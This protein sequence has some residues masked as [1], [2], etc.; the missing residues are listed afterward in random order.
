[1]KHTG[2]EGG[3]LKHNP[4]NKTSRI[5]LGCCQISH[6]FMAQTNL[7]PAVTWQQLNLLISWPEEKLLGASKDGRG[8]EKRI[9]LIIT[10]NIHCALHTCH[11]LR[12]YEPP[13]ISPLTPPETPMLLTIFR[14]IKWGRGQVTRP[15]LPIMRQARGQQV[16]MH[17]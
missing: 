1:M 3:S 7:R 13:C 15:D 17:T 5:T 8:K 14:G 10:A 11:M 6:K 4:Q 9:Q 16:C 2:K 12:M